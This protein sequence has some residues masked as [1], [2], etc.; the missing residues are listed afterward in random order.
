MEIEDQ[1][2]KITQLESQVE[3]QEIQAQRLAKE[4]TKF[5]DLAKKRGDELEAAKDRIEVL[6]RK[7]EKA[8][9]DSS[10]LRFELEKEGDDLEKKHKEEIDALEET[11]KGKMEELEMVKDSEIQRLANERDELREELMDLKRKNDGNPID[12][13][14]ILGPFGGL[15]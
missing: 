10:Q 11:L 4:G 14:T 2:A 1:A 6:E 7:V 5:R 3:G 13:L 15:S 9:M 8:E 12:S